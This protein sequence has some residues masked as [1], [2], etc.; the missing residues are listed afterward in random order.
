MLPKP[1]VFPGDMEVYPTCR[2]WRFGTAGPFALVLTGK[3]RRKASHGEV[4]L[5]PPLAEKTQTP[6]PT[7][8]AESKPMGFSRRKTTIIW[9]EAEQHIKY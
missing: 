3:E 9:H 8:G 5:H 4:A 6:R 1:R 7:H 2:A